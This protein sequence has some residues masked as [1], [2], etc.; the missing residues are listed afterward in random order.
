LG[1]SGP[2][3]IDL[4]TGDRDSAEYAKKIRAVLDGAAVQNLSKN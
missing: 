1:V 4:V 2:E 3:Q